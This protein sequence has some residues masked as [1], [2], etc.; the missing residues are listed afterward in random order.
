MEVTTTKVGPR[1][2]TIK[3][4]IIIEITT[5]KALVAIEVKT[6]TTTIET[7][8]TNYKFNFY[9]IYKDNK[10]WFYVGYDLCII[11]N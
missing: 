2:T 10:N 5:E 11:K 7:L 1:A 3:I 4:V 6:T 9:S 8:I